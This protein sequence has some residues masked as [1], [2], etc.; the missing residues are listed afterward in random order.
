VP[1]VGF[2]HRFV[3]AVWEGRKRQTIRPLRFRHPFEAGTRISMFAGWRT[4][5]CV[6]IGE[7]PAHSVA[8]VRVEPCAPGAS[9]P[10]LYVRTGGA[11]LEEDLDAMARRD[12]FDDRA[13]GARNDR[14]PGAE[15]VAFLE[16]VHGR[17]PFEGHLVT[18]QGLEWRCPS[19][20][21]DAYL[22]EHQRI[23]ER[24]NRRS[25]RT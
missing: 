6:K 22:A 19:R 4:P 8:R 13:P 15:L 12:G 9:G 1:A 5:R 20:E 14:A 18:W 2:Q 21:L 16:L 25:K 10:R 3:V 7:A 17:L 11:W 24:K 23:E